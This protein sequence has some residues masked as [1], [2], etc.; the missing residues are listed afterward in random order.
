MTEAWAGSFDA[1]LHKNLGAVNAELS[2]QCSEYRKRFLMLPFGTINPTQPD[3]KEE[4]RRCI[5]IHK[6]AG[7]R[8]YPNY[9]GYSLN[10][11]PLVELVALAQMHGLIVQIAA[12][13][14]D[15]RMQ[16]RLMRV[17]NVDLS[18]LPRLLDAFPRLRLVLLNWPRAAKPEILAELAKFPNVRFDI[19]MVEGVG[20]VEALFKKVGTRRVVFGS[21]APF[22]YPEAAVLKLK[23][24]ALSPEQSESIHFKSAH[25]WPGR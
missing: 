13:M 14:E 11:S 24:S 15:E 9:H 10:D 4:L 17:A 16:H 7:I 6:M 22:Y 19:A 20:G 12:S 5:E 23:E 3:W 2:R 8:L 1:L 25:F 18:P 21:H